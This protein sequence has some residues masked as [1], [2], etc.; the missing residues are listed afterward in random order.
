MMEARD[1]GNVKPKEKRPYGAPTQNNELRRNIVTSEVTPS[2]VARC[3]P[4]YIY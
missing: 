3:P 1:A 4:R 2:L